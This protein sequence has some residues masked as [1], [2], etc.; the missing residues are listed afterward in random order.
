[1]AWEVEFTDEFEAWWDDLSD[2]ERDE[3]DA[4]VGLLQERGQHC[5]GRTL[6][7]F[8]VLGTQT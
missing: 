2:E 7:G 1:V 4:K 3:I 5:Q 6:M 8:T